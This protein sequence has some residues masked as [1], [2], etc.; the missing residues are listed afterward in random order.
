MSSVDDFRE[1]VGISRW[2]VVEGV[3]VDAF[4]VRN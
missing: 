4:F 2:L 1:G 3:E